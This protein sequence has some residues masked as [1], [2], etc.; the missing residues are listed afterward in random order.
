MAQGRFSMSELS[1]NDIPGMARLLASTL[2]LGDLKSFVYASTG[3]QLFASYV[4]ENLPLT[5]MIEQLLIKLEKL[6]KTGDFLAYVYVNRPGKKN[7]RAAIVKFFPEAVSVPDQKIDLSAQTAGVP[8]DDAPTNAVV[9][10][11]QRN[12]RPYLAKL[13][14]RVWQNRLLK[15]ERQVCRVELEGQALGT[16]FLVGPD[17]VLTNWHVFE[18]AKNA[19]KLDK[20]GCRFDYVRLP[21][22]DTDPGQLITI[23]GADAIDGSPYS[24]AEITTKPDDPPPTKDQLDY[25]L[26]RLASRAGEQQIEGAPRGWIKLPAATLPLAADSPIL[27]VQHPEGSPMKLALDTQAVI[28]LNGNGTR[29]RYRTNTEPGSSGS[30]V[31]T[32]DWD[33][34]ALHHSGDPKWANPAFNQGVPIELIQQRLS[35]KGLGNALG[36]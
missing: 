31:F 8:Q 30:P 5:E 7:V 2:D 13:D 29:I 20:I 35:A 12:V 19:G 23:T 18:I 26:L 21:N 33:I 16:G 22:G 25:A 1:G 4:P 32:M 10:G 9:P 27:I 3:D 14:V 28:G 17:T 36:R 15:I 11:L 34:V 24:A 6:G